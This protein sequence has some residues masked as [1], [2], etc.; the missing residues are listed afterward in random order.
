MNYIKELNAF[1][2]WL[3][4]NELSPSAINLWYALMHINNKAAWAE[5][6]TVAESVL[7]VKTGLTDRTLRK[8]RNELKQ[9]NRIDFISRKGGKA[10]VYKIIQFHTTE[11]NSEALSSTEINSADSAGGRSAGS[12]AGSA[13]DSSTLN[14]LKE[15]KQNETNIS[16]TTSVNYYDEYYLCFETY[17][18]AIQRD[19]INSFIDC[20]GLNEEVI[21][22]AFKKAAEAGAKYPYARSIL[23]NWAKK[24]IK[25][26]EDVEYEHQNF[27]AKKQQSRSIK[28]KGA[29]RQEL[30]PDW[31]DEKPKNLDKPTLKVVGKNNQMDEYQRLMEMRRKNK[32]GS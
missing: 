18:N 19:E 25:T 14:K 21:C 17:P 32:L 6:F 23:N 4:L 8:V 22:A 30:L 28:R 26:I 12:S 13:G 15:T 24:G 27:I 5:T 11:N 7:C 2:D 20:D 29:I 10:P 9:K 16:A 1:Y 3:E 31:F